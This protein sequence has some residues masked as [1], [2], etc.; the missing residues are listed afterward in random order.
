MKPVFNLKLRLISAL[1]LVITSCVSMAQLVSLPQKCKFKIG[2]DPAWANQSFNDADWGT[3]QLGA[4]LQ[5]GLQ[6]NIYAWFRIKIV[7]PSSMKPLAE[8]GQGV[9]LQ[10]GKIDD[11][12]QTF[13]NGKLI[14]QSGSFPPDYKTQWQ[15]DRLYVIPVNEVQWDKENLISV[16]IFSP[17]VWVGMYQGPYKYGPIQWSDFISV[18][19]TISETAHNGFITKVKFT[20]NKNRSFEGTI[21]YRVTNKSGKELFTETK[22]VQVKPVQGFEYEVAFSE[23]HPLDEN[24]FKVG[25]YIVENNNTASVTNEQLYLADRQINI[26]VAGEPKPVVVN[27]TKDLFTSIPF[28]NQ[29]QRGYLGKRMNQNLVERLLKL[30][31]PGTLDGYLER[32]GHHPWAG[33]HIGKYL[34][35]AS[36]VWKNTGDAR[37]KTQMDRLM[38]QLVNSQLPDGYL[39]TYGPDEYWT[40]WDVWSHKY[41]L[42]G[43]LAYYATTGYQPALDACK[44][45]GDLLCRTFGNKPGQRDIILAGTHMGMAATS[46]LDPMVELYRY[47]GD[48]KYLDFCY[49]ILDAWEQHNGPKIISSL[50]A[51]GKVTKVGNGKAYEM[52]SNFVGLI[53]LYRVTGDEKLLKPVLIAWN[54]IVANRLYIT[55]TTSSHE[56]FQ[57]E[58]VLPAGTKDNM[59]EGCV[60]TTWIQL[61]Q[62]LLALT[63]ELKY[64]EQIEKAVYNHLLA[65][66]N[67]LT[68]CVSYYTPLMG[69]KPYTCYITC[70]QS[71]VPR[72]IAMIPYFTFGNIKN[73]PTLMMYEPASYK[74]RII[75]A[76]KKSIS[77][78]LQVESNFPESGDVVVT[79][80][81]S[82]SASFPVAF[83]VPSWSSSFTASIDGKTYKG[84]A[85]ESLV[86]NRAWKSGEK[87]K[88][89]FRMPVQILTGGK[90]Y[91]GQVAFQ[92]GP[93]VLALDSLLN[94][95][96]LKYYPLTTDQKLSV[97]LPAEKTNSVLLPVQ[98]IGKQAYPVNITNRKDNTTRPQLVLVPFADA[99]QTEGA[100]KVWL[101]LNVI[102]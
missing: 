87:I 11:I 90:S 66:E 82:Q 67:P 34:E 83:R 30:D 24:I 102:K 52:L 65:A 71:S 21:K 89:S 45:M 56:Y 86:V 16:R 19:S 92:R 99:S 96:V 97:G 5:S 2:D 48:K 27:K 84:T 35:T 75:T 69:K 9:Q 100:M 79:V 49:Y 26:K 25:Y 57:E 51:T 76:D 72:G 47:T 39:G 3:T 80:N 33:E 61:N 54:D 8:K 101:P 95:D 7:I 20:N 29:Q 91:P 58:E 63:G 88:V 36:N 6:A 28:Q 13:F 74:E 44:N 4:S 53:K 50:L 23:Y 14:G 68:G 78:S 43:L 93:Q 12:D 18:Q 46:V 59:G 37:L 32:P 42:Y 22:Q 55:G 94:V 40:S 31:E 98:W 77:L 85:N 81:P 1:L 64:A 17:D 70:C 41:N 73:V 62:N 38:Y 60:T 10:L 15:A